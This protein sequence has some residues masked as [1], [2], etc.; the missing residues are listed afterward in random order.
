MT[1][2]K[3]LL[4]TNLGATHKLRPKYSKGDKHNI[5]VT[6]YKSRVVS[7]RHSTICMLVKIEVKSPQ[8]TAVKSR[9]EEL[10]QSLFY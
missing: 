7:R 6:Q 9:Q 1:K 3:R 2:D 4:R 8:L 10:R 5:E